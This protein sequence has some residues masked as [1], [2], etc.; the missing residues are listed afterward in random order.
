ME[1]AIAM[2][3]KNKDKLELFTGLKEHFREMKELMS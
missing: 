1:K 2:A 3:V